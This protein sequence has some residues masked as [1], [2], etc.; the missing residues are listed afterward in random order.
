MC[1]GLQSFLQRKN[2]QKIVLISYALWRT[3]GHLVIFLSLCYLISL[4]RIYATTHTYL[5]AE[6]YQVLLDFG[7]DEFHLKDAHSLRELFESA[8]LA[9]GRDLCYS[10]E[11]LETRDP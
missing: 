10:F 5:R 9:Y 3:P 11:V 8:L 6:L 1:G 2:F 7:G 4:S